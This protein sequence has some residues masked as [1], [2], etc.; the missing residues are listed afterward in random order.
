MSA[1]NLPKEGAAAN[2]A[3]RIYC[4]I[5]RTRKG[6]G[7]F[8]ITFTTDGVTFREANDFT[9]LSA[10]T[11]DSVFVDT[12]PLNHTDKAVDLLRRGV[13]VYYLRRLTL[14]MRKREELGLSS[15]SAKSDIKAP[16]AIGDKWFRR[17]SEDFL[18]MRRMIAGYRSLNKSH[19]QLLNKSKALSE[20]ERDALKPAIKIIEEQM[21]KLATEIAGE[22]GKRYP[23]YNKLVDVLGIAGNPTA[24]EA[25]AEVLLPEWRSWSRIRAYFG[26]YPRQGQTRYH[27]SKE[28]RRALERLTISVKG[29]I[30]TADDLDDVLKRIWLTLKAQ[31]AGPPA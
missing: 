8:K 17:V 9:E 30:K 3:G 5:H 7:G 27:K 13:E 25:L 6:G 4:D 18:V 2:P 12:L 11:G 22:A 14:L 23:D 19:Q 21:S 15:K 28:G 29:S 31:K 26:A 1:S 10:L 24:L 16:M 20:Y